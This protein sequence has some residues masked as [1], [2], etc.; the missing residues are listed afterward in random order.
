MGDALDASQ[1]GADADFTA[2]IVVLLLCILWMIGG[3][4]LLV[5]S[6]E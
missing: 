2:Q 3:L 5:K 6:A 1:S 4:R